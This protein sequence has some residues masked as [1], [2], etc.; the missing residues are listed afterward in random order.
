MS[1][2]ILL[3]KFEKKAVHIRPI[4]ALALETITEF[5]IGS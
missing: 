3:I 2:I 1:A 4:C 5:G